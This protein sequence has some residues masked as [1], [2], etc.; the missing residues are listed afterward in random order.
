[1]NIP[2]S[3]KGRETW[4]TRRAPDRAPPAVWVVGVRGG[5]DVGRVAHSSLVL[6]LS[7]A[8]LPLDK[9][10]PQ[11]AGLEGNVRRAIDI[12]EGD[13]LDEAALK[14]FIRAAVALNLKGRSEPKPKRKSPL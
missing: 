3:R 12:H 10:F 4:G 6:D 13:K 11:G 9:V 5:G 2:T 7:G 14:D 8:V 1:M